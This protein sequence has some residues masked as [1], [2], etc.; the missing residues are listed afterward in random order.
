MAS[1]LES[2]RP[3]PWPRDALRTVWCVLGLKG[4]VLGLGDQVLG[5]G[6]DL[7]VSFMS[8]A[9]RLT[10]DRSTHSTAGSSKTLLQGLLHDGRFELCATFEMLMWINMAF[11]LCAKKDVVRCS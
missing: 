5:I 8:A 4:Q 6:F 11:D 2:S 3:C 1:V 7:G 9:I 10:L